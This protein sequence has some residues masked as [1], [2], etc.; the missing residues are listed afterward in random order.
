MI[1]IERTSLLGNGFFSIRDW[2]DGLDVD[3]YGPGD[4]TGRLADVTA[5][6]NAQKGVD[7]TEEDA[8]ELRVTRLRVI[9]ER[10]PDD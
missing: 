4:L 9:A 7:L 8:G 1:E 10:N 2:D 5:S 6:R 3:E